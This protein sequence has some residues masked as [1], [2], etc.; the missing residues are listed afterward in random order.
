MYEVPEAC[1]VFERWVGAWVVELD[2]LRHDAEPVRVR[3]TSVS[4]L[5]GHGRWLV[6]EYSTADRDFEGHGVMGFDPAKDRYVYTWVDTLR[7]F[8]AVGEG[9]WDASR[10]LMQITT[11]ASYDG[12]PMH[13]R[14]ENE[15]LGDDAR[16]F[17]SIMIAPDGKEALAIVG[18]Y[19]RG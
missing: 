16:A 8:L 12:R 3:G 6:T 14:E 5:I 13:W 11:T 4:R 15:W 18:V 2:V 10:T 17:R 9:T 7:P 1:R 19:R